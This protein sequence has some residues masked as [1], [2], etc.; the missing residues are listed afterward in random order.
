MDLIGYQQQPVHTKMQ[1][2]ANKRHA[3]RGDMAVYMGVTQ[4]LYWPRSEDEKKR[5]KSEPHVR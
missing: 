5:L 3:K 2:R 1:N 4:A